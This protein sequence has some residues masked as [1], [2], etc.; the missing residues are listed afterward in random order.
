MGAT[1]SLAG[2]ELSVTPGATVTST[3]QI[4]NSGTLVD[5]F[6]VDVVGD[7]VEWTTVEPSIINLMPGT[8]G[9]VTVTF[10]P[11]RDSTVLAGIVPFGIRVLSREEPA[12]SM[13]EEGA[14]QVEP[15]TDLQ[16]ELIPKTSKGR[17]KA[18]HELIVDNAGNCPMA[19]ELTAMDP[20]D[21]LKLDI[22]HPILTIQPGTSAFLRLRARPHDTFLR[23]AEKRHPFQVTALTGEAAP[24]TAN[25]T[26]VQQQILPK[27]LLPAL[28]ALLA[29]AII[30]VTLWFTVL[31]PTLQSA[32]RDT[33]EQVVK[34]E[35]QKLTDKADKAEE[36]AAAAEQKAAA[37]EKKVADG[38]LAGAG[39]GPPA[40]TAP[41]GADVSKGQAFDFRVV[42]DPVATAD[43]TDF[44]TFTAPAPVPDGKTLVITDLVLQNPR[45]DSGTLRILRGDEVLLEFGL[46]NFRDVDYHYLEPLTFPP[47]KE[48][49]VAVN[50]QLPGAPEPPTGRCRPSVSFSGR[51][52]G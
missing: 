6:T 7:A 48:L 1:T 14:I 12:A 9:Q 38:V 21:E 51:L 13:V 34:A 37:A 3:V 24:V 5:Q 46:N 35:Q 43:G 25:G 27:W 44:A 17:R 26:V 47:G 49:R 11:P 40:V 32:A 4:R 45:G 22:D 52:A 15:F 28:L 50:C 19:V 20:D 31:K 18:K 41:G 16:I 10:A 2:K 30:A 39:G 23:G 29:L 8:E 36:K 33:A 42:T